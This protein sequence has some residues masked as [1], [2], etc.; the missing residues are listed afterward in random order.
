MSV[1]TESDTAFWGAG[2]GMESEK[3]LSLPMYSNADF[4]VAA[5][6]IDPP[7]SPSLV[8][9]DG[10]EHSFSPPPSPSLSSWITIAEEIDPIMFAPLHDT[11]NFAPSEYPETTE[12]TATS[13]TPEISKTSDDSGVACTPACQVDYLSYEWTESTIQS[14]R[15]LMT[16]AGAQYS[17]AVRLNNT[18]WREWARLRNNLGTVPAKAIEW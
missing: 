10:I 15:K 2:W 1:Y 16:I 18:L 13:V 11:D 6:D 8:S 3:E 17:N 5:D 4:G 14:A 7:S 9:C 12:D